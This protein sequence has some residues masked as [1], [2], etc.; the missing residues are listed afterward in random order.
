MQNLNLKEQIRK[1]VDL[2]QVDTQIFQLDSEKQ[3]KPGEIKT[4]EFLF[5]EKK[6]SLSAL[7]KTMLDLLKEK[8]DKELDLASKEENIKKLQTQLYQLKTNKEYTA[9]LNEIEGVKADVSLLE[10][11]LLEKLDKIDQTKAKIEKEKHTLTE[12][13]KR[14]NEEKNKIQLRLKEIDDSLAQLDAQRKTISAEVDK[15]ILSRYERILEGRDS[16]AIVKVVDQ[17][18]KG[19]NMSVPPQMIN[20]IKMYERI[21]SCE[22]C[23]RILYLEGE[24]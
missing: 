13:E 19:C 12:E 22:V 21:V 10:D 5:E 4:L 2:Q 14:F 11:Q 20:L 18:C 8:K 23:Q 9:M 1:L 16:L 15:K 6:K 7:E 24:I 17:A 3:K